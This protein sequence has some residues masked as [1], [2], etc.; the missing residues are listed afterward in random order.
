M[1][2]HPLLNVTGADGYQIPSVHEVVNKAMYVYDHRSPIDAATG[3]TIDG[4]TQQLL[5][6]FMNFT[7]NGSITRLMF[8]ARKI[9]I[10]ARE[11]SPKNAVRTL[12]SWPMF[13]L[14]HRES[15]S[16]FR[17]TNNIRDPLQITT[18]QPPGRVLIDDGEVGVVVINFTVPV[19]FEAG[20]ILGLRQDT[21][22]SLP[23]DLLVSYSIKVLGQRR[24]YSLAQICGQWVTF[25][26]ECAVTASDQAM[27]YIAIETCKLLILK[28]QTMCDNNVLKLL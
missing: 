15:D 22:I 16:H 10:I 12:T 14:W 23:N 19:V 18:L 5:F 13:S 26:G 2:L 17:K 4:S 27:P 21:G 3:S 8:V 6:P 25:S 24:G 28:L 9:N 11:S 1:I 20:N 7:C